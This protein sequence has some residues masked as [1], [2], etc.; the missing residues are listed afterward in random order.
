VLSAFSSY[1]DYSCHFLS[2]LICIQKTRISDHGDG[3]HRAGDGYNRAGDGG[4]DGDD[5]RLPQGTLTNANLSS[6]FLMMA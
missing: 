5:I 6:S 1:S 4:F 2:S 3:Y